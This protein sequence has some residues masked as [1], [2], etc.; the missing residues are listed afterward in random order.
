MRNALSSGIAGVLIAAATVHGQCGLAGWG[1]G[2]DVP[3][4]PVGASASVIYDDGGGPTVFALTG[5]FTGPERSSLMRWSGS[6]WTAIGQG[7]WGY[8]PIP[9]VAKVR[10]LG[11]GPVILVS[12]SMEGVILS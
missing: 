3:G 9:R 8:E 11:A 4:I 6:G 10:N 1:A 2:F 7:Y 12:G 5:Q